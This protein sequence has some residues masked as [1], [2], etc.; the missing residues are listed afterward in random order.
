MKIVGGKA[1]VVEDGNPSFV[2]ASV[3]EY[4]QFNNVGAGEPV[5]SETELIEKINKDITVWKSKQKEREIRQLELEKEFEE[6]ENR[7]IEII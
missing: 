5:S 3:D 2:I 6:K 1:I 4:I 7:G